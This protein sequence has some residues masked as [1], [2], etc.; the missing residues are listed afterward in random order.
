M[1][2]IQHVSKAA[3]AKPQVRQ[4]NASPGAKQKSDRD[5]A[6]QPEATPSRK[7]ANEAKVFASHEWMEMLGWI[8]LLVATQ[9]VMIIYTKRCTNQAPLPLL[10]CFAQFAISAILSGIACSFRKG[11]LWAP[12]AVLLDVLPLSVVW[13]GGFILFNAAALH[14]SPGMVNVIRCMEPV[15]TVSVGFLLGH[16]FRWQVLATLLPI[17]GGVAM[18]SSSGGSISSAGVCFAMLSNLAFCCRTFC[19]QRLQRNKLNQLDDLAVFFNV[20]GLST[21]LMP[22]LE[23][24]VEAS[25]V[26]PAVQSLMSRGRLWSFGSDM[27]ASS[28]AFFFYQFIQLLVM[29]KLSPLAFSVLTPIVKALMIVTLTLCYGDNI[30]AFSASGIALSVGGGYLFTRAKSVT[31]VAKKAA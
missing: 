3:N 18:A 13:T 4:R 20:S 7:A 22:G 29:S 23:L 17:C 26:L 19:L 8:F 10:L 31:E 5:Q 27:L 15:A 12:K 25:E 30:S 6:H 1:T 14:M 21:F 28:I 16:R 9:L 24:A 2:S 11:C